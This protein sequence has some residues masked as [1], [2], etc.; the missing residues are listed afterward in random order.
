MET[1]YRYTQTSDAIFENIFTVEG[2]LMNHVVV[3]PGQAFPKHPTDAEVFALVVKGVLT[4]ALEDRAPKQVEAGHLINIPMGVLSAL[5]NESEEI[6]ELFV[7][8]RNL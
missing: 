5:S 7:V 2:L 3:G 1:I 8:K 6:V 4:V